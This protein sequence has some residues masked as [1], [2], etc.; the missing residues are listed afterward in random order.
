MHDV[1]LLIGDRD[2]AAADGRTFDRRDP[3]RGEVATR[4]R[5]SVV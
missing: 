1:K 2:T 3:I 4:D 5:K